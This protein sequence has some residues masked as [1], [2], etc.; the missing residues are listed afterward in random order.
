MTV[1][2]AGSDGRCLRILFLVARLGGG[3]AERQLAALANGLARRGHDI[4]IGVYRRGGEYEADVENTS[5]RLLSFDKRTFGISWASFIESSRS[6][7]TS[8]LTSFTGTWTPA[9]LSQQRYG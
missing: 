7:R 6:P 8:G 1:K 9:T 5:V 3:G 2:P 4:T